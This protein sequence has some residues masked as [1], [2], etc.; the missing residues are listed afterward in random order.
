MI[1]FHPFEI[2]TA[3]GYT[4]CPL[5]TLYAVSAMGTKLCFY[6]KLRDGTVT[7]TYIPSD[8]RLLL[9]VAPKDRWDYD[10]LEEDGAQRFQAVIEE[11]KQGCA[12]L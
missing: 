11:I 6:S 3:L 10:I 2:L 12:S 8:P 9:D 7:P 1:V 5:P 4:D